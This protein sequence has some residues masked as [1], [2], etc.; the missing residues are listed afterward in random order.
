MISSLIRAKNNSENSI[1][2][3]NSFYTNNGQ[4]VGM[5]FAMKIT[6][7]EAWI[8]LTV[9]PFLLP[10]KVYEKNMPYMRKTPWH[11]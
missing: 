11:R 5:H 3:E 10:G 1:Y 7:F 6:S 2:S 9:A 4:S 8:H